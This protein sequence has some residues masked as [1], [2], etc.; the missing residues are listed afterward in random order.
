MHVNYLD[1]LGETSYKTWKLHNSHPDHNSNKLNKKVEV[2]L[3]V[4]LQIVSLFSYFPFRISGTVFLDL[5]PTTNKIPLKS[6]SLI[7]G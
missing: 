5:S 4:G 3:C 1:K 7:N 6:R 2:N